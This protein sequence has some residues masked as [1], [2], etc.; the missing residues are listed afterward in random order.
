MAK[1]LSK[2]D[3]EEHPR[4][5]RKRKRKVKKKSVLGEILIVFAGLPILIA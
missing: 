1:S 3:E 5:K 4:K 2:V